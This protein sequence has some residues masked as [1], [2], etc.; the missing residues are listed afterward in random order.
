[1]LGLKEVFLKKNINKTINLNNMKPFNLELALLGHRI[2]TADG[3]EVEMERACWNFSAGWTYKVTIKLGTGD[4]RTCCNKDGSN[5]YGYSYYD[6]FMAE[7]N[8]WVLAQYNTL[9][10][11]MKKDKIVGSHWKIIETGSYEECTKAKALL[12]GEIPNGERIS[13]GNTPQSD[14]GSV[15]VPGVTNES[16][17]IW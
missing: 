16:R 4:F 5:Y 9:L 12:I 14:S 8:D 1:M 6:L 2:T 17:W 7:E 13:T 3:H 15:C 10:E 11:V